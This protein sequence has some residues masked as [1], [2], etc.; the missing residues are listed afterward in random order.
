MNDGR[1][2]F[3]CKRNVETGKVPCD[4]VIGLGIGEFMERTSLVLLI[5]GSGSPHEQEYVVVTV[6]KHL[7]RVEHLNKI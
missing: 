4:F 2:W 5:V 6:F 1:L 7:P 3:Y